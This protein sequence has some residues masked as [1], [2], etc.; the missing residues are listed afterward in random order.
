MTETSRSTAD[1]PSPHAEQLRQAMGWDRLP[2]ITPEMRAQFDAENERAREA[3]RR[4]YGT[5][6]A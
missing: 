2:E 6:A 4:F 5:D 3:A 1:Q